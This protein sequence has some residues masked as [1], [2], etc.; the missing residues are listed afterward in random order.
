LN[1]SQHIQETTI[2]NRR[3]EKKYYPKVRDAIKGQVSSLIRAIEYY[4]SVQ[5]GLHEA[6]QIISTPVT[7]VIESMYYEIGLRYARR[8][9]RDLQE[10]RRQAKSL[11]SRK[12]G[13][14]AGKSLS[15]QTKGFGFNSLWRD[16]I[17][18]LLGQFLMEM[19]FDIAQTTRETLIRTLQKSIDE[20]WG[21]DR[22]V[23]ELDDLPI[24]RTQAARIVR[25]EVTRAANT[26]VNVAGETSGF[27]QTKEWISARDHR[28]RG[29]DPE[30]HASHVRLNGIV[31]DYDDVFID[32][33]NKDEL[34]YPGDPKAKAE[35]TVNCRCSMS[36]RLKYG[37]DG[38][39]IKKGLNKMGKIAKVTIDERL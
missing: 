28:T 17:K 16:M 34:R 6:N 33:R 1:R 23:Q 27:E 15:F 13:G 9:H 19:T 32:P 25:T 26:G 11:V 3:F 36:V 21:V 29:T 18:N 35:S 37:E 31:V 39:P 22:T 7:R 12:A 4:G 14:V 38:R 10:Q 30:D 5:D 8:T 2:L 24:S 20:G